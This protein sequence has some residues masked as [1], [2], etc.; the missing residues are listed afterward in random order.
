MEEEEEDPAD[1]VIKVIYHGI[2]NQDDDAIS[3][4]FGTNLK[5]E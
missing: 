2:V 5:A 1:R 3:Q 4:K